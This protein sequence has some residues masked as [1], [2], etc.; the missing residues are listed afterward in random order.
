MT[1]YY[2]GANSIYINLKIHYNANKKKTN[3]RTWINDSKFHVEEW[4]F[5]IILEKNTNMGTYVKK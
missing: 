5:K 2:K 1:Q 4:I 3:E